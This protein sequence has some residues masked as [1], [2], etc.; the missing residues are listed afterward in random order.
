MPR[1]PLS[2]STPVSSGFALTRRKF[3]AATAA[4]L[5]ISPLLL[6]GQASASSAD[7]Q[8]LRILIHD[9]WSDWS[10]LRGGGRPYRFISVGWAAPLY[11]DG[12]GALHPYVFTKWEPNAEFTVWNFEIDPKAQFSD[13]SPITSA[14]V[15]ES[16]AIAA[17]PSVKSQR[18]DQVLATVAGW[19]D[20]STGT[21][22][23]F[24][25]VKTTGDKSLEVTL[26]QSDPIFAL[27]LANHIAPI[28]KAG[29]VRDADGNERADWWYPENAVHSGP[30]RLEKTD[31]GAGSVRFVPNEN[32]FGP[33]PLLSAVEI[34]V[35]DD[36]VLATA[37]LKSGQADAHPTLGTAT[38]IKD[39]GADFVSGGPDLAGEHFWI[40]IS[41][42]PTDDLRV[43]QALIQAVDRDQLYALT[44]PDGPAIK[45]DQILYGVEGVDPTYEPYPYDPEAAK[46]A[47]AESSYGSAANLPPLNFVG[48]SQP[49]YQ[50][51]AEYIAEQWRQ[52]LGIS[53]VSM[54]PQSDSYSGPEQATIQFFRDD[55]GTG[56]PDA[57]AYLRAAI[58]SSSSNAKNK[59]GN[60]KNP[61]ID[62]LLDEGAVKALD[63]PQRILLAQQAQRLFRE[64]WAFIPWTYKTK[65]KRA[66]PWA[67]GF[68]QNYNGQISQPWL[69]HIEGR[70]SA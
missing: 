17:H 61:Q 44:Y 54:K 19:P 29:T 57:V 23:A 51:A 16:W 62:K 26:S 1:S 12:E 21:A 9:V 66:D 28:I 4:S 13:G 49:R 42:K 11:Y 31:L 41:R 5:A 59:L 43:R 53:G 65:Q 18:A 70:P 45:A 15:A 7:E 67:K 50:L 22:I 48:I 38:L 10:P 46:K 27:K 56:V 33:K 47:L 30:F 25:G 37:L 39:L 69:V 68:D 60:Y 14:D 8:V 2:S 24:S 35:V 3:L 58:H 34:S 64:E 40:N 36:P 6:G 63:D 55:A 20:V 32:F 52:I